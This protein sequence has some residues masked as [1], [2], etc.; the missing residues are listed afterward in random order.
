[1]G[2][3]MSFWWPDAIRGVNQLRIREKTLES[4]TLWKSCLRNNI[5]LVSYFRHSNE[6]KIKELQTRTSRKTEDENINKVYSCI[7][8]CKANTTISLCTLFARVRVRIGTLSSVRIK[9]HDLTFDLT[10]CL[11]EA[12]ARNSSSSMDF[13][14]PSRSPEFLAAELTVMPM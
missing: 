6:V 1:M 3:G 13:L 4:G 14:Q 11:G 9:L 7:I 12:K 10:Y 2:I 5:L 8:T